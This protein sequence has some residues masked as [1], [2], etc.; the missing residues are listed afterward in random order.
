VNKSWADLSRT[1]E[2]RN[3][4]RGWKAAGAID[5]PTLAAIDAAYPDPRV[6]LHGFWRVLVFVLVSVVVSAL[7][8]FTMGSAL[9]GVCLVFGLLLTGATEAVRGSRYSGTG[10]DAATSFWAVGFLLV[11]AGD[12][13]LRGTYGSSEE[14]SITGLI[15]IVAALCA[16]AAW[17]WGFEFYAVCAAAAVFVLIARL[18]GGRILWVAFAGLAL[19]LLRRTLDAPG[20]VPAHRRSLAAAF[21][22][23]AVALYAAINLL[24]L[25]H[26]VVEALEA[27][28]PGLR[29]MDQ[30]HPAAVSTRRL[31]AIA[32]ALYPAVFLAWGLRSR[33]RIIIGLGLLATAASAATLRFY[34]HIAPLWEVLALCGAILIGVAIAIQR[35]LRAQPRGE[36]RGFTA[37]ALYE[38]EHRISPLAAIVAHSIGGAAQPAAEP[39]PGGLT[40]GGGRYGGGGASG[41][42]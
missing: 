23:S 34:V 21:V 29:S 7:A 31:A 16:L 40:T 8:A 33:K 39:K 26:R 20:L 35:A 24:S 6:R 28:G 11:A 37:E 5:A 1:E 32:T 10:A 18:P 30:A 17:R 36:W 42:Y 4:A 27:Y 12:V 38:R 19:F 15:A 25:D 41:S 13:L 2:V 9:F 3:A 22:V 14:G